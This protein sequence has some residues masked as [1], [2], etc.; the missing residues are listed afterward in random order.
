MRLILILLATMT[1]SGCYNA[2]T[3]AYRL[4]NMAFSKG[5]YKQSFKYYL[6]AAR[7]NITPAQYAVG[8]QYYYGLG[9]KPNTFKSMHWFKKAAPQSLRA[10]YAI[11]QLNS[12]QQPQPWTAGLHWRGKAKTKR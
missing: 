10:V 5:N 7:H 6:Y 4:G 8:Y 1:L 9:T 12:Q 3:K 2:D 11:Q